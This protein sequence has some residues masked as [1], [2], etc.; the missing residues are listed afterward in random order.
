[1]ELDGTDGLS[2]VFVLGSLNETQYYSLPSSLIDV[3]EHEHICLCY[4]LVTIDCTID[5][6]AADRWLPCNWT[7]H[8]G[9]RTSCL[10]CISVTRLL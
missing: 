1:M 7:R 8:R 4:H 3:S 6:P 10:F 5:E 2:E 9:L